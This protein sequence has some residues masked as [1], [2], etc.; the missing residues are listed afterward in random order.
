MEVDFKA[1]NRAFSNQSA[2]YD[3][4]D[5]S[6]AILQWMRDRVRKHVLQN[7]KPG[8]RLL[9]LNAGTGL[10]ALF[11]VG[12]GCT[13]HATDLSDGMINQ[14]KQKVDKYGLADKL[15]VSQ[16]SYTNLH[17]FP[18][19]GFDYIFSNF[20]GLNCIPDL[21]IVIKSF[22]R[23]L[24]PG[25]FV[26]FVIMPPVCPWE[27]A[28]VLKGNFKSAFRRFNKA[29]AM[30]H[31]EGEYFTT[32]YFTPTNVLQKFGKDFKK[33]NLEGL[34]SISPPPHADTFSVRFPRL[35]KT[36]TTLDE[37]VCHLSPFNRWA[38]HFILT[39]QYLPSK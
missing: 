10:D 5:V 22:Q 27:I 26:T 14:I 13:V 24:R 20:G 21:S 18:D 33:I 19:E 6:N 15:S 38:D 11:F 32:Y 37:K 4:Y 8:N 1:V 12:N 2:G 39:V 9:E 17:S 16:C 28:T 30:A 34:A 29:G 31:L 3:T 36:L 25:G 35:Y 7:L 23:L